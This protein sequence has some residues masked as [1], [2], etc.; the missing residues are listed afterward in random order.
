MSEDLFLDFPLLDLLLDFPFELEL[1]FGLL[2]DF[3]FPEDPFEVFVEDLPLELDFPELL[4]E[5][6]ELDFPEL[7]LLLDF[8]LLLLLDLLEDLLLD[9]LEDLLL[10]LLDDFPPLDFPED[11]PPPLL[12]ILPSSS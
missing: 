1:F 3:E 9:L 6:D 5:L 8:P 7:L 4:V 12:R 10:D 2:L 11:L